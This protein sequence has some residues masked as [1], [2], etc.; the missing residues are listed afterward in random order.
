M[1]SFDAVAAQHDA[2]RPNYPEPVFDALDPLEGKRVLE[3]GAGTGIATAALLRRGARVVTFDVGM[4][5]LIR[6]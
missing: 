1:T 4:G 3:G 2:G 5:V 6:A